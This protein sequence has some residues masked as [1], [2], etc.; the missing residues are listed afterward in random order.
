MDLL[1]H[2]LRAFGLL[3]V[4]LFFGAV[5]PECDHRISS[6]RDDC[7]F[8]SAD[9]QSPHLPGSHEYYTVMDNTPTHFVLVIIHG[10]HTHFLFDIP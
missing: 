4:L 8:V 10:S 6:P 2:Q 1:K 5:L 3:L 9:R 7:A